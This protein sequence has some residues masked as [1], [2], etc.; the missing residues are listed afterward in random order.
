MQE[1]IL[2]Q[3]ADMRKLLKLL[4]ELQKKKGGHHFIIGKLKDDISNLEQ[5]IEQRSPLDLHPH[6]NE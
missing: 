4:L 6:S 3:L 2:E 1:K 5:R